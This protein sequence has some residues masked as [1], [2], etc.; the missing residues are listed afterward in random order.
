MKG[1]IGLI[2]AIAGG[3]ISWWAFNK[4]TSGSNF[5]GWVWV[6]ALLICVFG[7]TLVL[8]RI[9]NWMHK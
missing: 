8:V 6:I 3:A 5:Y 1:L 2:C 4:A 7:I 9:K